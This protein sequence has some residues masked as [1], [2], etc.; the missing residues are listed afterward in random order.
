MS[1]C[2]GDVNFDYVEKVYY[3]FTRESLFFTL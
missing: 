3:L 1:I 2:L